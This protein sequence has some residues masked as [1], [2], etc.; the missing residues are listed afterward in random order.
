MY[1]YICMGKETNRNSW[2]ERK[3]ERKAPQGQKD[4]TTDRGEVP[5]CISAVNASPM[6]GNEINKMSCIGRKPAKA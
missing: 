2:K 6:H 5:C 4:S 1:M 3:K